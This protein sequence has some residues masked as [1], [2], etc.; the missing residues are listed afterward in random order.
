MQIA[1]ILSDLTSLRVCVCPTPYVPQAPESQPTLR[2]DHSAALA[3]VSSSHIATASQAQDDSDIPAVDSSRGVEGHSAASGLEAE[4]PD[5][6]RALDLVELHYG[7]KE[8]QRQ[9]VE[10]GLRMA[11]EDVARVVE[12]MRRD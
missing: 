10:M 8:K 5:L 2:Q 11:R 9:G 12:G 7:V 1:S 4:D 3:L 6:Q